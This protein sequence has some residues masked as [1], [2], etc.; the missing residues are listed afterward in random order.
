[1]KDRAKQIGRPRKVFQCELEKDFLG[2]L[3]LSE[4]LANC[5]TVSRAVPNR[6]I[7]DRGIRC[8]SRHRQIVDVMLQHTAI[9]QIA[10]DIVEPNALSQIVE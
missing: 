2:G 9:E 7:E 4:L 5:G 3:I 1:M 6:V 8:E 10:R